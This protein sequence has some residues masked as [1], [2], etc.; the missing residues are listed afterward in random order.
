M[1]ALPASSQTFILEPATTE[2]SDGIFEGK[3]LL[4]KDKAFRLKWSQ[5]NG[6]VLNINGQNA[7]LLIGRSSNT[8]NVLEEAATGVSEDF[9]PNSIGLGAGSYYARITNSSGRTTSEIEAD[10]NSNPG[11]IIYSNEIRLLI[12]ADE[13]PAIISPRGS[14]TNPTPTFQWSAIPGVPS[15]WLIL[16]STPFD[17]VEDD[18]GNI[19]IEGATIVWQYITKGTTA[20]YGVINRDSPFTD[21][22]PPL[23]SD[24]EYSYT[25][26]NV[27]EENNPVLT[28]PVFGG[29]VP[30]TF[31][32]PNAVPKTNLL[33]P[34]SDKIFFSEKT[35]TFDWSKVNEAASYTINL[36]QIVKQQGIDVTIPIWTSTTT[37]TSIEYPAIENLKNGIYQWN[38]ITNNSTGGGTTSSGRF[39]QYKID[40]GEFA[41]KIQSNTD[42]SSLLGV[43]LSARAISKGVTPSLPYFVQNETHYDS[44]VAGVY[45]FEAEKSGYENSK[46]QVS[47]SGGTTKKFTLKM[48]PLPSSIKG[49]VKDENGEDIES[50]TVRFISQSTGEIE[51]LDT[52]VNGEFSAFLKQGTYTIDASKS[53]FV[54]SKSSS[55]TIGFN[56]QREIADP[57]VIVNDQATVS[58][59]VFNDEGVAIQ[60]ATVVITDGEQ[61]YEVKT[62]GSGVFQFIVSSGSWNISA[63]KIGFVKSSDKS[64][65]LS[66]GDLLQN[67][68][69]IL[70]GNANQVTGFVREQIINE[71]G[72]LGSAPFSNILVTAIP[73]VGSPISTLSSKNG[74]YTLSLRSGSYTIEASKVNFTSSQDLELVIGI[75]IGETISGVDF[76][77]TPNPSSISGNVTL[78]DGNGVSGAVVTVRNVGNT[79]TS[80]SGF[81]TLSTPKGSHIVSVSKPGLVSP[82]SKNIAVSTGQKLTGVNFEMTPNAGSITGKIS[83][84]G[85]SL[86]NT[87]LYAVN[88]GTGKRVELINELDGSYIFNLQSGNWYIKAQKSGFLVDSTKVL[89]VGAGQQLANQNLSLAKNLTTVSGIVTD[90]TNPIRNATIRIINITGEVF[91][92]STVTKVNGNYAFSLPSGKE[93]RITASKDGFKSSSSVIKDLNPS[94]TVSSD[95]SLQ[96]N[97][98]SISGT[99]NVSGKS[100]LS[101][102][103]LVAI[104]SDGVRVD[105][106]IT[107]VDGAYILGLNPGTYSLELTK[108]GYT[109]G[110]KVST[111]A[112]GQNLSG[113]DFTLNENFVFV[114]GNIKD[115]EASQLEQVFVNFTKSGGDGASTTTDQNGDFNLSGLIGGTY[116]IQ[117]TKSGFNEQSFSRELVDGEFVSLNQVLSSKN[118]SVSGKISDENGVFLNEATVT[119]VN[120]NGNEYSTITDLEGSFSI[121]SMDLGSYT[122]NALKTGYTTEAGTEVEIDE[123]SLN[124]SNINVT[125]LIPNNAIIQGKVTNSEDGSGVKDVR[126]SA[127]GSRGSGFGLTNS[128][129]D[130]TLQNLIPGTYDL[131]VTKEGFKTDSTEVAINP[132]SPTFT[133]NRSLSE[134][135]GKITGKVVDSAGEKLPFK[136]SLIVTDGVNSYSI[137]SALSGDFVVEN[138]ETDLDYNI[139][140]DIYRDG[141]ENVE[142]SINVPLGAS[143]V[144]LPEQL[145]VIVRK[146]GITGNVGVDNATVKLIKASTGDLIELVTSDINGLY[147][148]SFLKSDGYKII[149]Q[150]QGYIFT[151]VE[152]TTINLSFDEV[153]AVDFSVQENIGIVD[154][155]INDSEG[156]GVSNVDVTII[157]ADTTVIRT[158]KTGANGIISFKDLQATTEYTIRPAKNGFTAIP[159]FSTL[160]LSSGDSISTTFSITSN[161]S[162]LT[163]TI[164]SSSN[165]TVSNLSNATLSATLLSTGQSVEVLTNNS[166]AYDLQGL[167]T[168]SYSLVASKS[169]FTS[170]TVSIDLNAGEDL[171]VEDIVL[172]KASVDLRGVVRL[173]GDGVSGVEVT[174]LSTTSFNITTNSSGVFRFSNVPIKTGLNDSTI[175]QVQVVS[176]VF[177]KSY[178]IKIVPSQ[179]GKTITIPVTNLPSGKIELLVTDGVNPISG[180]EVNFGISGGETETKI[181]GNDGVFKSD[182]NLRQASYTVS[183]S[184]EGFLFPQNTVRIDLPT[185]TSDLSLDVLLPYSQGRVTEILADRETEVFVFNES[186]YDNSRVEGTLFYKRASESEFNKIK[187]TQKEDSLLASIP[188][189]GSVEQVTFFTSIVDSTLDNTFLSSEISIIPLASGILSNIRISPTIDGQTLRTGDTYNLELFVRDGINESLAE[190]FEGEGAEGIVN[191]EI[192]S[193]NDGL[194]LSSDEGSNIQMVPEK[195][196]SYQLQVQATLDGSVVTEILDLEVNSVP[197]EEISVSVPAKQVLNSTNHLFSYSAIDTSGASVILGQNLE[198]GVLPSGSG[199]IDNRG[200]FEPINN[201]I[202]GSFKVQIYD[203]VS[204]KTGVSDLVELV[205]RIEPDE[206]YTLE[207][208]SGLQLQVPVGSVDIP[209]QLSLAETIPPSTKKFIFAQGTDVSYT[210]AD[211]IYILS[212]SGSELKKDAQLTLPEDSSLSLNSGT[213]KIAR[214]NFTTLQWEILESLPSKARSILPGSV[215]TSQL[216]QFSIMAENE[217]IGIKYAAVL[218]SPF[219]PDIAPVKIGYWLDTAFPPAKVDIKIFNIRGE[220]VRTLLED[221]LQ[222]PGRYGS[223]TSLLPISWDGLTDKGNMARNGRYVIQIKAKDQQKE[224]VKLLQVI[225]VK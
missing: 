196:G 173:N 59:Y 161:T 93:Y 172:S 131:T 125:D 84:N 166:G 122:I 133:A 210:V 182:E 24:Q 10:F 34:I 107:K 142:T 72:T 163:G 66:T 75:A 16:S 130:Y 123:G 179:V 42:N 169:G 51:L 153:E 146:A 86:S 137:Q 54:S 224:V 222:Q 174:A 203:P 151:P 183:V 185:D 61:A 26:L 140:T 104:N 124:Q 218:P 191:W 119:A 176:G 141:Y 213:K 114:S 165:E 221:D 128:S 78:P 103:K 115:I 167:A 22:A 192:L 7:K 194:I 65:S 96:G 47:I 62:N 198:W 3:L 225:L 149:V 111:L 21:E 2:N 106:T 63:E 79:T 36:F 220:L 117:F 12:E 58:G 20:E 43:E 49:K 126:V 113:I 216:G 14:I 37:N 144:V 70:A 197:I 38:V 90:G 35:I 160:S 158:E 159:V 39:F 8:Y 60:R 40:T 31:V 85:E 118:G 201:S 148:F 135:K 211:K 212:F 13:A 9:V 170:D 28:S 150:K 71:D 181:T 152:S 88:T 97:P 4:K 87:T 69:F 82:S 81:Y 57:F 116:L 95:F 5:L 23:N 147:E 112:I 214:F 184:K 223:D 91:N 207:D 154:V 168:G 136:V 177:S 105:S 33:G 45:E 17:I 98:S 108:P 74:Q 68:D 1:L 164:K 19:A 101:D 76:E 18:G 156:A 175:Y 193:N 205:A 44:L 83:N 92:Q 89:T 139:T 138:I 206:A 189:I 56:E 52:N 143:E 121:S 77:L 80:N 48:E 15:Y 127:T 100:V 190:R 55:I 171:S 180:A 129:G 50:A 178:L 208:G 102:A 110:T 162:S 25:V 94:T 200:V 32:D 209:S 199:L 188:A 109:S 187:M 30:F 134:N 217:P 120:T 186:G 11:N 53:G 204:E 145:E 219:S 41:A 67:Q 64:V 157:S 215:S 202:I 155:V 29:I 195:E 46:I 27:Y 6:D 73:N 99:V 132:V